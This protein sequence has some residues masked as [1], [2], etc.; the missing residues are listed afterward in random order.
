MWLL[1]IF[2]HLQYLKLLCKHI[3][4]SLG[5]VLDH[6]LAKKKEEKKTPP[7]TLVHLVSI[8]REKYNIM[9]TSLLKCMMKEKEVF[10]PQASV[11]NFHPP[12]TAIIGYSI[13][14]DTPITVSL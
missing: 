8:W 14:I 1:S 4:T 13:L 10:K 12:S 11:Y 5:D 9:F 7:P 2:I 6:S 3:T